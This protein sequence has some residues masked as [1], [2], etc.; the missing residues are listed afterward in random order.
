M[1]KYKV[2]KGIPIPPRN[3]MNTKYPFADMDVGD[4]FK[5]MGDSPTLLKRM[6]SACSWAQNKYPTTKF[7]VRTIDKGVRV[8]RR[9]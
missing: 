1:S 4:S 8:W 5:V 3:S 2:E 9:A 7:S 6:R